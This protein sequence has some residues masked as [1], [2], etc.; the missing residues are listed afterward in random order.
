MLLRVLRFNG[1][2]YSFGILVLEMLTGIRP[3]D[4]FFEDGQN[5]HKFVE[6]SF[7]NNLLKILDSSLV[8]K[9]GQAAIEEV[10]NSNLTPTVE[11]CLVSLFKIGLSCPLESSKE[12]MNM[13]DVTREL[14][15]IRRAF[16]PGKINVK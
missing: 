6:N 8:P 16:L 5:L 9:Q 10:N 13:V 12:R 15:K 11:K 2:M 4:E 7:P 1:D 14:S 3:T